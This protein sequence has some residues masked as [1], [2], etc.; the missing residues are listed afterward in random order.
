[1][2]RQ[3]DVDVSVGRENAAG[4]SGGFYDIAEAVKHILVIVSVT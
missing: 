4:L 2:K 1:M 3:H